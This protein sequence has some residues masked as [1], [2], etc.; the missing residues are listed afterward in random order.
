MTD[1]KRLDELERL[2]K[3]ATPGPWSAFTD[4]GTRR[5]HT[6][7][8]AVSPITACVHSL[9]GRSKREAD[10]DIIAESRNALPALIATA[11]EA[12][13]LRQEEADLALAVQDLAVKNAALWEALEAWHAPYEGWPIGDIALRDG[14][15]TAAR[16]RM[17]RKALGIDQ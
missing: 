13:A 17:T 12:E 1:P 16:V 8:V 4:E 2:E 11:R 3:A 7:I 9:P 10:V 6:N 14:R 5:P 15:A